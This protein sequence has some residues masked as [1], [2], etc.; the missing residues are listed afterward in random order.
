MMGHMGGMMFGMSL[1]WLVVVIALVL[2]WRIDR[3]RIPQW[4]YSFEGLTFGR[5]Q[6]EL[7]KFGMEGWEVCAF[8]F[9]SN[10]REVLLKRP[11]R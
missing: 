2:A 5:E 7:D 3:S 6:A 10:Q 1:F 4:E 11:K 9:D 8:K